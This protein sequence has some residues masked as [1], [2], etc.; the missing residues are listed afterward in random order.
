L[1]A[2]NPCESPTLLRN[3]A[4]NQIGNPTMLFAPPFTVNRLQLQ[5]SPINMEGRSPLRPMSARCTLLSAFPPLVVP[6][7]PEPRRAP[8]PPVL[9]F[10][11][12][13]NHRIAYIPP[14]L[15]CFAVLS[16]NENY[17]HST[18]R[19]SAV[20]VSRSHPVES[21]WPPAV[22]LLALQARA[23]APY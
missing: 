23:P 2:P 5:I 1:R 9:L 3:S 22:L 13:H 12:N 15:Q 20:F 21:R 18:H 7:C 19:S 14:R 8:L 4:T 17:I 11:P 6:A 10:N 16:P